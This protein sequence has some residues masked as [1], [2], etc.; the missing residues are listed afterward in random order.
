MERETGLPLSTMQL[1]FQKLYSVY[2]N[3][4]RDPLGVANNIQILL[5]FFFNLPFSWY[6]R[7]NCWVYQAYKL[8]FRPF[9]WTDAH[10][11]YKQPTTLCVLS[12]RGRCDGL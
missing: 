1:R 5:H 4:G 12:G 8:V 11:V 7:S 9:F 10:R 3:V 2:R 6:S